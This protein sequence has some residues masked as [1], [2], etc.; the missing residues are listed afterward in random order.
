MEELVD[1]KTLHAPIPLREDSETQEADVKQLMASLEHASGI[2]KTA[3]WLCNSVGVFR[4]LGH[5]AGGS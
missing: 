2:S 5:Y 4:R 3:N 1:F